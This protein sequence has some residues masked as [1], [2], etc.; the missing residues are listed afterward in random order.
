M[1]GLKK[2]AINR[3]T[4]QAQEK[5][6]SA[7]D[8]MFDLKK[9]FKGI[10][11]PRLDALTQRVGHLPSPTKSKPPKFGQKKTPPEERAERMKETIEEKREERRLENEFLE[12]LE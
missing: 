10:A 1:R 5:R 6:R 4:E 2:E 12:M 7:Y 9:D 11:V 3:I 8:L